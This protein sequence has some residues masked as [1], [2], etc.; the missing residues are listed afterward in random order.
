[1]QKPTFVDNCNF[2]FNIEIMSIG[3]YTL[4]KCNENE[5]LL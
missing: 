3:K 2:T 1:M 5:A 4:N